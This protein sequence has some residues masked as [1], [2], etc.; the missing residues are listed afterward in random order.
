MQLI[1]SSGHFQMLLTAVSASKDTE[2]TADTLPPASSPLL[3]KDK[4]IFPQRKQ[5]GKTKFLF[6]N[7][8]AH[9]V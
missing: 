7:N 3:D 4:V 9:L 8:S 5:L 1:V 6:I 2:V